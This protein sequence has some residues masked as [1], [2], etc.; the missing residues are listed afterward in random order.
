MG[1]IGTEGNYRSSSTAASGSVS[2]GNL[3]FNAGNVNPLNGWYRA[4]AYSVRCVQHLPLEAVRLGER[5]DGQDPEWR[6]S[7]L[8]S[9]RSQIPQ[10]AGRTVRRWPAVHPRS[11]RERPAKLSRTINPAIARKPGAAGY[12]NRETGVLAGIG[13]N[14]YYWSSSPR[15]AS[16]IY[17]ANLDFNA[18]NVNPLGW[19]NRSNAFS[20]RC[21]QA[22]AGPFQSARRG[23]PKKQL[24]LRPG[25][26]EATAFASAA[27]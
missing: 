24:F 15:S 4:N 8:L 21:V 1:G 6:R 12:R 14:G 17:A 27:G 5:P 18:S 3:N 2:A 11:H 20:V 23:I 22:S 25:V 10:S 16:E 13:T 19:N 26:A 9:A 7:R